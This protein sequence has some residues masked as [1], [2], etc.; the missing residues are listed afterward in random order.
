MVRKA[1]GVQVVAALAALWAAGGTRATAADPP[2]APVPVIWTTL[3]RPQEQADPE[4]AAPVSSDAAPRL[5]YDAH[6]DG[7]RAVP[8]P[9]CPVAEQPG[10][11]AAPPACAPY[12]DCN[13]PLLDGDP[14]LDRPGA[15]PPGWLAALDVGFVDPHVKN[16][17][18]APVTLGPFTDQLH[19]PTAELDAVGSPRLELGYRF[20]QGFGEV[21]LSYR[22]L[23][24][25]GTQIIPQFN[26]FGDGTLDSRLDVQVLDLDYS[27]REFSLGPTWDMKWRIGARLAGVFFDSVARGAFLWER[28]S[29][30]FRG[31]GPHVGLDLWHCLD[32]PALYG[33]GLSLFARL[34]GATLLGKIHQHFEE[35]FL[36][37]DGTSFLDGLTTVHQ[38][39]AVP[40]LNVQAGVGWT[41]CWGNHRVRFAA[42]YQFED[43][44]YLGQAGPSRAELMDQGVFFR[45]E[46]NY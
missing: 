8:H 15:P 3:P 10:P 13:G 30:C 23:V 5:L 7:P 45:G 27:T 29:N 6:L 34:E 37:A 40:V 26:P 9:A 18:V 39:Q 20:A 19:L 25:E 4:S 17:L 12:E 41:P 22:S 43:W 31:V 32:G 42:G 1:R 46:W 14:L 36:L 28:T 21:L 2:P 38:S 33:S 35:A 16:R 24:S 44:W 11:V